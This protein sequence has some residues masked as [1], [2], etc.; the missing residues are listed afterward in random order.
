ML[1]PNNCMKTYLLT[2]KG[3][4]VGLNGETSQV[5]S[6]SALFLFLF[7]FFVPF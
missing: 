2:A 5:M 3:M 1:L 4:L 6:D 7:F